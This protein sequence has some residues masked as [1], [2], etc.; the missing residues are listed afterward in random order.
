MFVNSA[1]VLAVFDE[2]KTAESGKGVA[3]VGES[4]GCSIQ[5]EDFGGK[6]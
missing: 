5:D 3:C 6:F 4:L 2:E 1:V